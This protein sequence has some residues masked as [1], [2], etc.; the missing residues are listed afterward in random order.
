MFC[1]F[2]AEHDCAPVD[3]ELVDAGPVGLYM[4]VYTHLFSVRLCDL[5]WLH[6][7]YPAVPAAPGSIAADGIVLRVRRAVQTKLN[8]D[9][10]L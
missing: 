2:K 8:Q 5:V 1:G 4:I 7:V 9:N 6:V 10:F 3:T